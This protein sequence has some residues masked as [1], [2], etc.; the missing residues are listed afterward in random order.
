MIVV[1]ISQLADKLGVHRNTIRNWIRSGKLPA[2][3]VSGKRYSICEAN[4]GPLSREFGIERSALKLKYISAE[5]QVSL[6]EGLPEL[7]VRRLGVPSGKMLEDPS[8][9]N[10][11]LTCG[12]CAC[13]CPVSGIDGMDPRKM[14]R[15][16]VLG[17]EEDILDSRWPWICTMCGECEKACPQNVEIVALV[18]RIRSFYPNG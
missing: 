10:V 1:R 13:V 14:V 7:N 6:E 3:A 17:L 15:M 2:R 16:A 4:L 9:G 8:L 18:R 12:S 5:P 11:C